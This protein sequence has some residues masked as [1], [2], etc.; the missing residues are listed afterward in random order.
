MKWGILF[1][2][3][4]TGCL[5]SQEQRLRSTEEL[6]SSTN[7]NNN[8]TDESSPSIDSTVSWLN[9]GL[10]TQTLTI[11]FDNNKTMYLFGDQ[12]NNFLS[13]D[14]NMNR[15]YCLEVLFTAT[16]SS[17]PLRLRVKANPGL[18]NNFNQGV[19]TRYLSVNLGTTV[20]NNYCNKDELRFVA[21]TSSE[22]LFAADD[23]NRD[24]IVDGNDIGIAAGPA[25]VCPT[26][27][28]I[29]TSSSIRL[30]ATSFSGENSNFSTPHLYEISNAS[31]AINELTL[32]I[33]MNGNASNNTGACSDTSCQQNGFDCCIEGQC[34]NEAGVKTAAVNLNPTGFILAEQE[35]FSNPNWYKNYPEFYFICLEQPPTNNDPTDPNEPTDPSGEAEERLEQLEFDF[36]CL[37]QLDAGTQSEPFHIDFL[38]G[39]PTCSECA[40]DSSPATC[41]LQVMQRLYDNCGCSE[42]TLNGSIQNCPAYTYNQ[43]FQIGSDG[44]PT[45]EVLAYECRTPPPTQTP[46]PFS[47]LD[48]TVNSRSAPHR[49]FNVDNEEIDPTVS[50]PTG[51]DAT[52]EGDAFQYLDDFYIFPNNEPFSMN[53]ILGQMTVQLN[54][55]RP[56]TVIDLEFDKQY[57][58]TTRNG[59]YISCPT[60]A[61]DSWF[62]NFSP[63][64]N[65][66]TGVG[67]QAIGYTTRRD[68]FE[69]N[70][71]LGNYGDTKFSRA[72][73]LPPTMIPFSH[74]GD[75]DEQNQRLNRLETQ[76]ALFVNGYQKDWYGFNRGALIGSF[77]GVTWFA[78]GKGRRVRSTST[79][80]FLA[81]NA[82]F[83]DLASPSEHLVSVQEYDFVSTAPLY[84]FDPSEQINSAFQNEAGS[85][86][87]WHQCEVDADCITRLGWE[88]SCADVSLQQTQWPS[89][90]PVTVRE[91][92]NAIRAGTI[93]EFLQ[94]GTLPPGS[95]TRRCVYRGAGAPCRTDYESIA[96]EGVRKHFTCA[97]NF[98]CANINFSDDFN[99]EVARFGRP[100]DELVESKNHFYGMDANLLGR[101]KHYVDNGNLST[102]PSNVRST[103]SENFALM[104]SSG[105]SQFGLCRPGKKLPQYSGLTDTQDWEYS[106]QHAD[107]DNDGKTDFISQ[108]AGCNS[109]LFT[110]LRYSS[111][112]MLD[113]EGNY[114]Q[115][116]DDFINDNFTLDNVGSGLTKRFVT[117]KLSYSQNACGL[118]ALDDSVVVGPST[119]SDFLSTFSAFKTIEAPP[120]T[121]SNTIIEPTLARD[122]CL[123][124]AGAVCHTDLDCSPNRM[125]AGA[126]DLV[127]PSFFGNEAEKKYYEEF[128]ICGQ[129]EEEP[130]AGATDYFEYN[131]TNNRCCR[132][133]G[134]NLTMYTEDSPNAEESQGL[135]SHIFGSLNPTSPTRY[136]R[137]SSVDATVNTITQESNLIR[138]S[139]DTTD[140]DGNGE[141]DNTINITNILQW[142]TIHE[143]AAKTCCGGGWVRKFEDGT[144]D[145]AVVNRLNINLS[146]FQCLNYRSHLYLTENADALGLNQNE[147]DQDKIDFCLDPGFSASGCIQ[148]EIAA[149]T[150]FNVS[151][152]VIDLTINTMEISTDTDYMQSRWTSNLWSFRQ[153]QSNVDSSFSPFLDWDQ[154]VDDVQK[155][156]ISVRLPTHISV[157]ANLDGSLDFTVELTDPDATTNP[158]GSDTITCSEVTPVTYSC[159]STFNP[160]LGGASDEENG[161]L[162]FQ[163]GVHQDGGDLWFND[164]CDPLSD[165]CCYTYDPANRILS[166]A[167]NNTITNDANNFGNFDMFLYLKDWKAVGTLSYEQDFI[168]AL[169][170]P[171]VD[172]VSAIEGRRSSS[173]GNALYYLEK[174]ARFEYLGIPQMTYEPIYCNDNYQKMVP[175]LFEEEV[176]GLPL[177][178]VIEFL[179]HPRTFRDDNVSTPWQVDTAGGDV[180]ADNLNQ[181]MV[182][183]QELVAKPQIFSD[184]QF[185]C[186]LELGSV[187]EEDGDHSVCCSGFAADDADLKQEL[188]QNGQ[189]GDGKFFCK[190]PT[191]TDLNVYFNKFVS[192][193]GLSSDMGVNPL[194]NEDFDSSTGEPRIE[195]DVI[196][197][198]VALGERF[199]DSNTTRRGAVI[200]N[201]PAQPSGTQGQQNGGTSINSI[202][203]SNSDVGNANN[204]IQG[205][206]MYSLGFKWNHH[207][208]CDL[209]NN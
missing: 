89:F 169:G 94:Q 141:L 65:S 48:V 150:D 5:P 121:S 192:G 17:T 161:G 108:I 31:M 163:P 30:L 201:F 149:I 180:D 1:L 164:L 63:F 171:L 62:S 184:N 159:G 119:D 151:K 189:N 127:D 207:I 3:I 208:Y 67:I 113:A 12:V 122:A 20:G 75:T 160:V 14:N 61:R 95:S 53:S 105:T 85:C 128:L 52:Q 205:A 60:C 168:N 78:I 36:N 16:S 71:T 174:L 195:I 86:Q 42:T 142:R 209:G 18:S 57:L 196:N 173:P 129:A 158:N 167:Y 24:G 4:F 146:N 148:H 152:P 39:T 114:V 153:L 40:S 111:C 90:D 135:T 49:F 15:V 157:D 54:L 204:V 130:T 91:E 46:L 72:C 203:D 96:D 29:L 68:T 45:E 47:D 191:G 99:S 9:S 120:L 156:Y 100:L 8:T 51:T 88:Y 131:M 80:L 43:V 109:A 44:Q 79:K 116:Q 59:I 137:Y 140:I 87:F 147:L 37:T 110:D 25:Q 145:W 11:D 112:P 134:E 162:C 123:R 118:E 102:L 92:E 56:A 154:D 198:L 183:T 22:Q 97:P 177:T 199:C 193:E 107:N 182:A 27:L 23:S 10:S 66:Q 21:G 176:D 34:V 143:S 74:S 50:L 103:L 84:D 26:C 194:E 117:E 139:A 77:D 124:K 82:P 7:G 28:N 33:D 181:N 101:P 6:S 186:C 165:T 132:P 206:Q 172:D 104:D 166:V 155:K 38:S 93:A 202:A 126:V 64:P 138:V 197:K 41:T 13:G 175:G 125:M 185:K 2:L 81:I 106:E 76:A 188:Q 73:Y 190:L 83:A 55:A 70:I 178:N 69:T 98:Y 19:I 35:K 179:N 200:G 32:R 170:S 187:V 144:N 58:I 133:V 115:T 136:S